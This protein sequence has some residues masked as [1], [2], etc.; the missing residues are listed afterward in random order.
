MVNRDPI[1]GIDRPDYALL[2]AVFDDE[3]AAYL[4]ASDVPMEAIMNKPS[5]GLGVAE[6]A[7]HFFRLWEA[8]LIECRIDES[9]SVAVPDLNLA[10]HQ[11]W[12]A[13]SSPDWSK[14]LVASTTQNPHEFTLTG[15]DRSLVELLRG[16]NW[17]F[18][19]PLE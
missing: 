16:S 6:L 14:F 2:N 5:H 9:G 17:G 19:P 4:L 18:P 3:W 8:G 12:E 1:N 10:R 15:S 13:M 11:F 7:E